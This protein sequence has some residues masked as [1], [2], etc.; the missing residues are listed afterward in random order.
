MTTIPMRGY[1]TLRCLAC[2]NQSFRS[3]HSAESHMLEQHGGMLDVKAEWIGLP[4]GVY[5]GGKKLRD[6]RD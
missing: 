3:V 1:L 4:D 6:H 2:P 5:K